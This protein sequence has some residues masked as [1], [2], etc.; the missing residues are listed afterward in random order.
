MRYIAEKKCAEIICNGHRSELWRHPANFI[1][2]NHRDGT[3]Y[4]SVVI[5]GVMTNLFGA[6]DRTKAPGFA[7]SSYW[8]VPVREAP[9][10]V[11]F[12]D[13]LCRVDF[14]RLQ[15]STLSHPS[16]PSK[17]EAPTLAGVASNGD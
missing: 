2:S 16:K 15:C 4:H 5:K 17:F 12:A 14:I 11:D 8:D 1:T 3:A 10:T 7:A 9:A 13:I 6:E